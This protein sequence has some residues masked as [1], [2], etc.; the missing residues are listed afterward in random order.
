MNKIF[1]WTFGACFRTLGRFLAIFIILSLF[2]FIGL[3]LDIK[4]PDW[5]SLN[6]NASVMDYAPWIDGMKSCNGTNLQYDEYNYGGYYQQYQNGKMCFSLNNKVTAP[7]TSNKLSFYVKLK[8]DYPDFEINS[9]KIIYDLNEYYSVQGF[10]QDK[11][12]TNNYSFTRCY[13]QEFNKKNASV[14]Y[15]C[16]IMSSIY[17]YQLSSIDIIGYE[18]TGSTLE[19]FSYIGISGVMNFLSDNI[20]S[21]DLNDMKN[22]QNDIKDSI[23]NDNV[24]DSTNTSSGFFNNFTTETFGLTS[25]I[26]A[27]LNAINSIINSSCNNLVLPLPFVDKNLTLP[28]MNIIYS[29]HFK[30]FFDLYQIITTGLISYYIIVRIFNLVKDFKNPEHD[31]IE[32]VDL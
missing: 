27:P 6:V 16:D 9:N 14:Y 20:S 32:V 11:N 26:T 25:I 3:K 15:T 8:G 2:L 30:V 24:D 12:D 23:N 10:W 17:N 18:K 28:C 21:N 7:S 4:L 31:E 1:N 13:A 22:T 5:L 19:S 29:K